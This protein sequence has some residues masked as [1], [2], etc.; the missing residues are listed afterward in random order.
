MGKILQL[1]R[2]WHIAEI[3]VACRETSLHYEIYGLQVKEFLLM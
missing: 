3:P 2:H 1:Q